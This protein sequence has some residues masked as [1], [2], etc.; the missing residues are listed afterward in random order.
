MVTGASSGFGL[1]ISV[2]FAT[3]GHE[4]VAT[5]RNPTDAVGLQDAPVEILQLDV[6][7]PA[8]R[9]DA[10]G[11]VLERFG[12]IDVLVNNAGINTLGAAE[13]LPDETARHMFETNF[14]GPLGLMRLVIPVM[15]EQRSGR[16]INITS[17]A[18]LAPGAYEAVYVASKH[19][20]DGLSASIDLE[21]AEYG[22]RV[23]SVQPGPFATP[24]P[25]KTEVFVPAGSPYEQ[26]IGVFHERWVRFLSADANFEPVVDA[27]VAAATDA[28]P[29]TRY[30]AGGSLHEVMEP[31]VDAQNSLHAVFADRPEAGW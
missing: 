17:V 29:T 14:W 9:S 21:L 10:V 19:A 24:L 25:A 6:T 11:A 23:L 8:S 7:D 15:R 3:L 27:V 28:D 13:E 1:A 26:A 12:R 22:V 5:M 20:L 31:A 16:V 2:R 4:V 18:A 30:L